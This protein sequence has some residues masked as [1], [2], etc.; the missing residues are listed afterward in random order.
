MSSATS[1]LS[2]PYNYSLHAIPAAYMLAFPP[3]LY[4]F[5]KGMIASNYAT[6]NMTPRT[7]LETL[8]TKVDSKTF[9]KLVRAR[10]IHLNALEGF[11]FFAAAMV[12]LEILSRLASDRLANLRCSW[13]GTMP[14]SRPTR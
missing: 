1:A 3:Y 14:N 8:K 4:E 7:N 5:A 2:S 9:S 6:T 11:P 13:L 12:C 10:G